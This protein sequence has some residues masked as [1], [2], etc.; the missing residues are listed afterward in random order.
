MLFRSLFPV[1]HYCYDSHH[2]LWLVVGLV[3]D[4]R[5]SQSSVVPL[6]GGEQQ[7]VA[8]ARAVAKNPKILLCDEPTGAL[9]Y[10]TGKQV[11]K[12]L[13]DKALMIR[14][15]HP[16]RGYSWREWAKVY[17]DLFDK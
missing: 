15:R 2:V 11:L 16:S 5:I 12:I 17:Q 7:R 9:D 4:L 8:L 14:Q 13:Q 10:N 3:A 6:S 1:L